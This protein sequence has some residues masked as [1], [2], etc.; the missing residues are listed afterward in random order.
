M[1]SKL[2]GMA[3]PYF[4]FGDVCPHRQS[5][6]TEWSSDRMVFHPSGE[7]HAHNT[8]GQGMVNDLNSRADFPLLGA[9]ICLIG[10]GGAAAGV[11]GTL[12]QSGPD[13]VV[14][15]NRT[16]ERATELVKTHCYDENK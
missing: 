10:A 5:S 16:A 8:D 9:R 6:T 7:H 11:L 1:D 2:F 14:I 3:N 13:C 4:S 15:T 12:L